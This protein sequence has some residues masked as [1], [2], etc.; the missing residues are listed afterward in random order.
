MLWT[1][2]VNIAP[3][4]LRSVQQRPQWPRPG[5]ESGPNSA[6]SRSIFGLKTGHSPPPDPL[7]GAPSARS[8]GWGAALLWFFV[9]LSLQL[10]RL[11][12]LLGLLDL[13]DLLDLLELLEL[14][15]LVKL[16]RNGG[17]LA[18]FAASARDLRH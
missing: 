15:N 14:L 10:L 18:R 1:D 7:G 11:L 16:L 3:G 17:R 9:F 13:L 5:S 8:A 12:D 2:P 4:C 6:G